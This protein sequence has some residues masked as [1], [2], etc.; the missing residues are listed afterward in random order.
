MQ[1]L[2]A[3]SG[4]LQEVVLLRTPAPSVAPCSITVPR[5]AHGLGISTTLPS[6]LQT[7]ESPIVVPLIPEQ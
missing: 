5:R 7:R 1:R 3:L 6:T 2:T 4:D